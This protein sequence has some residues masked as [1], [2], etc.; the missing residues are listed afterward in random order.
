MDFDATF[1]KGLSATIGL[2]YDCALDPQKWPDACREVANLCE[3]TAGGICVHESRSPQNDQLFVFGY[4]PEFLERLGMNYAAS[5][6]VA[7]DAVAEI[8]D[9]TALSIDDENLTETRFFREVLQPF[10]IRDIIWFPA[11]RTGSRM[12]SMHASRSEKL[13][14]YSKQDVDILKLISPHV[15]RSLAISDALDIRTLKS[16]MLERTLDNLLA[17]VFLTSRDGKIVYMNA[18]AERQIQGAAVRLV[19]NRLQPADPVARAALSKAIDQAATGTYEMNLASH[20]LAIPDKSGHGFVATILPMERSE[21]RDVF[22]PFAATCAIFMQD[23]QVSPLTP[24]EAFAKMHGLTGAELRVLLALSQGLGGKEAADMLGISE[25]TVRSHLQ[26][27]FAKT[28]TSRQVHLLHLLHNSTP[29]VK[30][31]R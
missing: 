29:P 22:A 5:P 13:A 8:G 11:L 16:E 17:G 15:C 24:G 12:A 20:S 31:A 7:S 23:P 10:D 25:P 6:M 14:F 1:L 19:N 4:Q 27:I 26:N 30:I 9:V 28:G 21:R 3:S 2:I 18:T